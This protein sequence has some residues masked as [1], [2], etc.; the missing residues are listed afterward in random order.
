MAAAEEITLEQGQQQDIARQ[1]EFERIRTRQ[2]AQRQQAAA[3][4]ATRANRDRTK[5]PDAA[6]TALEEK[7]KIAVAKAWDKFQMGT[8]TTAMSFV[9]LMLISGPAAIL[10]FWFRLVFGNFLGGSGRRRVGTVTVDFIPG[11]SAASM[12]MHGGPIIWIHAVTAIVYST[13]F[14]AAFIVTHPGS[15]VIGLACVAVNPIANFFSIHLK[16][17]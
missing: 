8:E 4:L 1:L 3:D 11:Y 12:V 7:A 17:L 6:S 13:I 2:E 5:A 15:S 16:C 9:D 10:L 14:L